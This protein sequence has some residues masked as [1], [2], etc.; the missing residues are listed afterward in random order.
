MNG[1]TLRQQLAVRTISGTAQPPP[2]ACFSVVDHASGVK[3]SGEKK[4]ASFPYSHYLFSEFIS[5]DALVV[6]FATH[7]VMISGERLDVLLD[8]LTSQR[9]VLVRVLPK[10][11]KDLMSGV[12]V[13]RIEIVEARTAEASRSPNRSP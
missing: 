5:G 4:T 1:A 2:G 6:R 7:R 11:Q 9:L 13:D 3:F 10:P 12:W 8:E